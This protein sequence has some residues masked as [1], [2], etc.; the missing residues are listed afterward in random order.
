VVSIKRDLYPHTPNFGRVARPF[1]EGEI[2]I[3]FVD[4][5]RRVMKGFKAFLLRGNVVDLAV[6]VVIGAAFAGLVGAI[7]KDLLTPLVSAIAKLPDFS[8]LYFTING[9]KFLYGDFFNVLLAFL[10]AAL[11]VYFLVVLPM[12]HLMAKVKKIPDPTTRKCP[13]CLSEI[14]VQAKRCR[15]CTAVSA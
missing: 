14:P 13:E 12:N 2:E 15:F 1:F 5:G 3:H 10:I 9:S 4:S 11:S 7:V 8:G 6:G